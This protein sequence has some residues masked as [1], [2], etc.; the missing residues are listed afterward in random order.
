M[1][2]WRI[3]CGIAWSSC[4]V[5]LELRLLDEDEEPQAAPVAI[6]TNEI[7]IAL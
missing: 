4:A 2:S 5:V 6:R 7:A 3:A 1:P